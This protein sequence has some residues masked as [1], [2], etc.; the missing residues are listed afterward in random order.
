MESQVEVLEGKRKALARYRDGLGSP[1]D[2]RVE[3]RAARTPRAAPAARRGRG[4][5]RRRAAC[6]RRVTDR[7]RRPGGP[8]PRDRP[9]DARR[10][11]AE[12][13]EHRPPGAD[14]R[15]AGARGP[16]A[17]P[18]EVRQLVAMVQQTL[19]ATKTF[20][21]DVRPMVLDDLGLVPD[22][23]ASRP[24]AR[25]AGR[26]ASSSTR[27]ARTAVCR[28][29][30]RAASSGSSTR[31]WTAISRPARPGRAAARLGRTA[32][33]AGLRRARDAVDRRPSDAE[34]RG[35]PPGRRARSCRRRWRR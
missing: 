12:P 10:P 11:G 26:V 8:A 14:R 30:S 16:G 31:R 32:R 25:P 34:R 3:S 2:G 21:F 13:D 28:W 1:R 7:P 4:G 23:A 19:E 22:A 17:A 35:R 24:R 27:W 15:A 29:S 6:R 18:G 20:I 9:G 33:G 5:R